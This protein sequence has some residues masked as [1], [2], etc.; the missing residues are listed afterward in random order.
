[1]LASKLNDT[2]G[3]I[4]TELLDTNHQSTPGCA[5]AV[6]TKSLRTISALVPILYVPIIVA[7]FRGGAQQT[8]KYV[9]GY[10]AKI[11]AMALRKS[12]TH[13]L[14]CGV[15]SDRPNCT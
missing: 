9:G 13:T 12:D 4:M 5:E 3:S 14:S 2:D 8:I 7:A 6:T 10:A 15:I 11:V 1:M